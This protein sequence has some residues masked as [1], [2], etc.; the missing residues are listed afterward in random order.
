MRMPGERGYDIAARYVE[1]QF[2]Q[3]GLEPGGDNGSYYAD[4][5]L[6]EMTPDLAQMTF[7]LDGRDLSPVQDFMILASARN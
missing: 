5:P 2:R 7:N 6:V 1:S 3:F 4:V